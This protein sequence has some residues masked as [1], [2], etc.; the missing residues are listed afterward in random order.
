MNALSALILAAA[1]ER[2]AHFVRYSVRDPQHGVFADMEWKVDDG[3]LVALP[4]S[5]CPAEWW[6]TARMR[7]VPFNA[8]LVDAGTLTGERARGISS[9][10]VVP[11]PAFGGQV[12]WEPTSLLIFENASKIGADVGAL[13]ERMGVHAQFGYP[14]LA[15]PHALRVVANSSAMRAALHELREI[16]QAAFGEPV[17]LLGEAGTGKSMLAEAFHRM[18][19]AHGTFVRL[20]LA[21]IPEGLVESELFGS[22]PGGFLGA[23]D[24]KGAF[25]EAGDGTVFLDEIHHATLA[26]QSKL[27]VV[28]EDRVLRRLGGSA[29]VP[30]LAQIVVASNADLP[31][32]V[33]AGTLL[34]DLLYRLRSLAVRVPPLRYRTDDVEHLFK[35]FMHQKLPSIEVS[36]TADAAALLR[37]QPWHGNA[38]ELRSVATRC[39]LSVKRRSGGAPTVTAALI[40]D[41]ARSLAELDPVVGRSDL[42]TLVALADGLLD[43]AVAGEC[44]AHDAQLAASGL[45]TVLAL[46]AAERGIAEATLTPLLKSGFGL[47]KSALEVD[48]G[49]G[50]GGPDLAAPYRAHPR[51]A[52]GLRTLSARS[53]RR[54]HAP[55]KKSGRL[56]KKSS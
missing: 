35:Q 3:S 52:E 20:N 27:L 5:L 1:R 43:R 41:A 12:G 4:P 38:R 56:S 36:L 40:R 29:S 42:A 24:R 26:I 14:G 49:D 21:A 51:L 33:R 2:K 28:L 46:L 45:K 10:V 32:M 47:W 50:D 13:A 6:R 7:Q 37:A 53:E 16:A 11:A 19:G 17:L 30:V 23:T 18:A 31:A 9:V 8:G 55:S 22:H 44:T 34:P 48:E 39:A 25:E 54:D 15:S